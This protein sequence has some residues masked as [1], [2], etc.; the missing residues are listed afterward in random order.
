MKITA[1]KNPIISGQGVCDPHV[2]IFNNRAYLYASHDAPNGDHGYNMYDWEIWS[3]DDLVTW[4]KESVVRP[5]ETSMGA[6]Y[7]CWAV[8]AAQKDGTYYLYVSNGTKET[9]VFQSDDPGKGFTDWLGHPILTENISRTRSYD[10]A[11]FTDDAG[12]SYI[13]FGTPVWAGG[14]SYYIARLGEDMTSLA[15]APRKIDLDDSA[16][17]KPFLH[18]HNGIYYLTWASF[19]A[20]SDNVYGPYRTRGNLGLSYD[21]GSFFE[22]NGQ[23]FKAFTVNETINKMRRATGLAY[24]HYRANGDMCADM[25]IREYGVGQY[26]ARW[27]QIEAEWYMKGHQVEKTENVFNGF[28]VVMENGSWMEFPNIHHLP[29]QPWLTVSGVSETDV[30]MEVYEDDRLLGVLKKPASYLA[31]G[32]F[33]KYNI[34]ALKL[35]ISA[36]DHSLRLVSRGSL[37]LDYLSFQTE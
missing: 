5:E 13:I 28:D 37:K 2:H 27:N 6:S 7:A 14:D 18:K 16:D 26:D 23:W 11:V 9:Y 1:K 22:W 12:Q 17:D 30:E 25:L 20:V 21:H 34:G 36:G 31:G 19:Y 32:E 35:P 24:I 33:T 10:P 8:D 3:S 4:E 15:E 29:D